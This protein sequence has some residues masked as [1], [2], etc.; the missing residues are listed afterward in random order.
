MSVPLTQRSCSIPV[1]RERNM[2]T[3][4]VITKTIDSASMTATTLP[5]S[6]LICFCFP[7]LD[8]PLFFIV[9]HCPSLD[10]KIMGH[11]RSST[12]FI[13]YSTSAHLLEGLFSD[14]HVFPLILP[15]PGWDEGIPP[16]RRP[17]QDPCRARRDPRGMRAGPPGGGRRGG[18]DGPPRGPV[19]I[20]RERPRNTRRPRQK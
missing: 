11:G 2:T 17:R 19:R 8:G 6:W 5:R 9:Y 3:L 14:R 4:S 13:Y 10:H 7:P 15:S 1:T 12:H 20:S 18:T 16:V